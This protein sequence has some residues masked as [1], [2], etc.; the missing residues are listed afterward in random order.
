MYIYIFFSD[1]I[2]AASEKKNSK[3]TNICRQRQPRESIIYRVP[4]WVQFMRAIR[5]L[6]HRICTCTRARNTK[7]SLKP[8]AHGLPPLTD[9]KKSTVCRAGCNSWEQFAPFSIVYIYICTRA[10]NTKASLKPAA[11]GI[12]LISP[13]VRFQTSVLCCERIQRCDRNASSIV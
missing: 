13:L 3:D 1:N 8:A 6:Q 4:C 11:H 12:F 10:R 9:K 7:A 5:T 2:H